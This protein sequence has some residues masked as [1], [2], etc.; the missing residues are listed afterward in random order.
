[1]RYLIS[2]KFY[3]LIRTETLSFNAAMFETYRN[4]LI[5]VLQ[6]VS[7][8]T[9]YRQTGT[10]RETSEDNVTPTD[11]SVTG[12]SGLGLPRLPKRGQ[13][14]GGGQASRTPAPTT[15]RLPTICSVRI[16]TADF[17]HTTERD[18]EPL[19]YTGAAAALHTQS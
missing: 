14:Q 17:K 10:N 1:M 12:A 16:H 8:E 6:L 18:T 2:A 13:V 5:L 11:A 19:Q 3:T 9:K 7:T 15:S 4:S